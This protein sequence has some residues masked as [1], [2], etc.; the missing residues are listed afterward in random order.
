MSGKLLWSHETTSARD[1]AISPTLQCGSGVSPFLVSVIDGEAHRFEMNTGDSA[2]SFKIPSVPFLSLLTLLARKL[3]LP[4]LARSLNAFPLSYNLDHLETL[5]FEA[6]K[7]SLVDINATDGSTSVRVSAKL[8]KT[9]VP[10]QFGAILKTAGGDRSTYIWLDGSHL[11]TFECST[12]GTFGEQSVIGGSYTNLLDLGLDSL[13][14]RLAQ[15]SDGSSTLLQL[16]SNGD[17]DQ[18]WQYPTG[19]SHLATIR[20]SETVTFFFCSFIH[21]AVPPVSALHSTVLGSLI[22]PDYHGRPLSG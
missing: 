2:E 21:R 3:T 4:C 17:L 5:V 9:S 18:V 20:K 8:A 10:H 15:R 19:V 16:R 1:P 6:N 13:G 12:T 22:S 11:R 7:A 14:I